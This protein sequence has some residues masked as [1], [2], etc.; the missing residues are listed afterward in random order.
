MSHENEI[1][2]LSKDV[3]RVLLDLYKV[4]IALALTTAIGLTVTP[5][6]IALSPLELNEKNLTLFGAFFMTI[7]PFYHGASVYLLRSYK[8]GDLSRK[9]A[10]L[11]DFFILS[12]EGVIFYAIASS[13]KNLES[14]LLW[15]TLLL[16]LDII[17]WGFSYFKSTNSNTPP[18]W[19]PI[20]NG[21]MLLFLVSIIG[22]RDESWIRV[23]SLLFAVSVV[24][25]F[26]D[27]KLCYPYYFP[28]RAKNEP[29]KGS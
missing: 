29:S 2:N 13:I 23:Y 5:N 16:V 21:A 14:F 3:V 22:M 26:L 1:D 20:L 19:W 8:H 9:G 15:F 27:Y 17:W 6:G 7:V 12:V 18:R 28:T 4:V 10:A 24:R 11:V 25:T